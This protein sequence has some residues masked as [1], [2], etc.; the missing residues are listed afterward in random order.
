MSSPFRT[1]VLPKEL[2]LSID[3]DSKVLALGS[4]FAASMGTRLQALKFDTRVNPFGTLFHPLSVLKLIRL[5]LEQKQVSEA[6]YLK[7]KDL[8]FHY[9]LHSDHYSNDRDALLLSLNNLLE[10]VRDYLSKT[11]VLLLT[12]GTAY[13]YRLKATGNYVANC[14]KQAAELFE[15]SLTETS[16][17]EE[18]FDDCYALLKAFNP[19]L[20]I[21]LTVSP[22]RHIK[23]GIE[24]NTVSKSVLHNLRYRLCRKY[25]DIHY[26]PAYEIMMDD[27][28]DYRFYKQDMLHP[29]TVATDYIWNHFSEAVMDGAT[30]ALVKNVTNLNLAIA[31]RPLHPESKDHRIFLEKTLSKIKTLDKRIDMSAE[32]ELLEKKLAAFEN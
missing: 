21:V 1:L 9:E 12:F 31:H 13:I 16:E 26:F 2:P 5:A 8:F 6:H 11:D 10:E 27:L 22:V 28:R 29:D 32:S 14:H 19:S 15:K 20:K 30:K 4:C 7:H 17:I 18:V 23:D 24:E 3:Y 25:A